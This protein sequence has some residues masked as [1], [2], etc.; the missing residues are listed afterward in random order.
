MPIINITTWPTPTEVKEKLLKEITR[1]THEVTGAALDKITVLIQEV[2]KASWCDAGI[3]GNDPDFP[4]NSRR[5]T[6]E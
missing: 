6:Y 3:L 1:V 5:K 2:E 4:V